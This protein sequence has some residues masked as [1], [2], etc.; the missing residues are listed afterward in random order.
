[1]LQPSL[2]PAR[3]TLLLHMPP[4]TESTLTVLSALPC[5]TPLP[6]RLL[7]ESPLAVVTQTLVVVTRTRAYQ[8]EC[9][10]VFQLQLVRCQLQQPQL[11]HHQVQIQLGQSRLAQPQQVLALGQQGMTCPR[12][13][14]PANPSLRPSKRLQGRLRPTRHVHRRV[15]LRWLRCALCV[16]CGSPMLL[17]TV[18][19]QQQLQ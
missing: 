17:R 16:L 10:M 1:M 19:A 11:V 5:H 18:S 7:T 14:R 8:L 6:M 15:L 12:H 2:A 4:L 3:H 9:S 13:C